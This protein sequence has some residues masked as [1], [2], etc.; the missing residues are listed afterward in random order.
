MFSL[1]SRRERIRRAR[2]W[3]ENSPSPA[4][5]A[6]ASFKVRSPKSA[7]FGGGKYTIV[8]LR[9][10]FPSFCGRASRSRARLTR[11]NS[12][13]P[14]ALRSVQGSRLAQ[15]ALTEK[16]DFR[17]RELN[18]IWVQRHAAFIWV[19]RHA[20]SLNVCEAPLCGCMSE[21]F[22]CPL[23]AQRFE[24]I[25][26]VFAKAKTFH[27]SAERKVA[28]TLSLYLPKN[29]T[30]C[31]RVH[32]FEFYLLCPCAGHQGAASRCLPYCQGAFVKKRT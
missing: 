28:Q 25:F 26:H 16:C 30:F 4:E 27:F 6:V 12:P 23:V 19:Q 17:W 8:F 9:R 18:F 24:G 13:F 29:F 7:I 14:P 10:G 1:F 22:T 11:K 15:S 21:H 2:L 31:A 32:G 5:E 3:R 20:A